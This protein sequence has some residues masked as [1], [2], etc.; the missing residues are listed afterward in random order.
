MFKFGGENAPPE[1]TS[2]NII[3]STPAVQNR[4]SSSSTSKSI[5]N[6]QF[7]EKVTQLPS[8]K[9]TPNISNDTLL[10]KPRPG[11]YD[12]DLHSVTSS[13]FDTKSNVSS[14]MPVP[15]YRNKN[16]NDGKFKRLIL[17]ERYIR[18]RIIIVIL[19]LK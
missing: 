5:K 15:V 7:S 17:I 10:L 16:I 1:N 18:I 19:F 8:T 3:P 13:E 11:N 12:D 6:L 2:N 4:L 14:V 9:S